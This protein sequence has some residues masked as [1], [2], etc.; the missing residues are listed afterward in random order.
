MVRFSVDFVLTPQHPDYA[1]P[2]PN[3]V[4]RV[5]RGVLQFAGVTN[6]TWLNQQQRPGKDADGEEDFGNIDA[7]KWEPNHFVLE[8]SWG[9]M[10]LF[11]TD[12][13]VTF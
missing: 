11:A 3:E 8:G 9:E 13:S 2:A 6:L 7:M 12:V 10:D 4:H 5:R 1:A